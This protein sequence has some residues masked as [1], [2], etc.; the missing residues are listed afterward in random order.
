MH[1]IVSLLTIERI[2]WRKLLIEFFLKGRDPVVVSL[3]VVI[4]KSNERIG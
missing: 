3:I 2:I 4:A 1:V